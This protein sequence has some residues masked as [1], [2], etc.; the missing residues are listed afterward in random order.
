MRYITLQERINYDEQWWPVI[1]Q[2]AWCVTSTKQI[3][4]DNYDA[5]ELNFAS[6]ARKDRV[7]FT[8]LCEMQSV[9]P[10]LGG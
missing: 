5:R 8:S 6:A 7:N 3:V 9:H 1:N 4:P 2:N 10:Q